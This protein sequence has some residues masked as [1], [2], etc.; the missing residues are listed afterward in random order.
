MKCPKC[1][2]TTLSVN[3]DFDPE[4]DTQISLFVACMTCPYMAEGRAEAPGLA[5]DLSEVTE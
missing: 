5:D 4:D 2:G 3:A 1:G